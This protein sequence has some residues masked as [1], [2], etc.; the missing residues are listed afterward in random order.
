LDK[1]IELHQ[2][3]YQNTPLAEI[4]KGEGYCRRQV[5]GWDKRYEKA[6]TINVP[7]F[8]YVKSGCLITFLKIQPLVLFIMTGALIM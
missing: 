7:S 8:H 6:K 5:E 4:G 3:P 2:V 1:L